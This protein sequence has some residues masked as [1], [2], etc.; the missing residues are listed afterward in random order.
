[1]ER[2]QYLPV[3]GGIPS[4]MGSLSVSLFFILRGLNFVRW[5]ASVALAS[6]LDS[7]VDLYKD[8]SVL[9]LGAGGALSSIVVALNDARKVRW[10]HSFSF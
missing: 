8:K 5:N 10:L 4:F 3:V 9:E 6:Y 7:Q 2:S 1:M